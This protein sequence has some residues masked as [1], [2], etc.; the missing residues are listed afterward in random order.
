[1][2]VEQVMTKDV[3]TVTPDTPLREVARILAESKI[4][5]I[6]VVED[7]KLVGV[8]SEADILVKERGER[9][10][11]GGLLGLLVD[12]GRELETKLQAR[13]AG[14]AMTSPAIT[15]EPKRTV[16]E[17]AATMV[18]KKV[19]RLPVVDDEG[20]LVGIVTR[21]DLVR[22]FVRSDEEIAREIREDVVFRTLWIPPEQ[23]EVEVEKGV[24]TLRGHVE[25]RS[26]A[27]LLAK[28]V[29]RVPGVIAVES[30][31]TWEDEDGRRKRGV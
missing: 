1:M 26:D 19:N 20:N 28:F 24:V 4:S 27:E 13:T 25:N 15:I 7:G 29:Q 31:L 8:V 17:A 16:T 9:P 6:P 5:G 11:R 30:S 12:E 21:A 22:A 18:E 23:V 10:G 3:K 2:R 14:E